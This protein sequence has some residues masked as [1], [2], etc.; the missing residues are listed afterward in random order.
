[1]TIR[2]TFILASLIAAPL[3]V[4]MTACMEEGD[5]HDDDDPM[6]DGKAD[7]SG[8]PLVGNLVLDEGPQ[9]QGI[10]FKNEDGSVSRNAYVTFSLSGPAVLYFETKHQ[11]SDNQTVDGLNRRLDT[12]VFVYKPDGDRWGRYLFRDDNSGEGKFS[13]FDVNLGAGTYH[14]LVKR[15]NGGSRRV[16]ATDLFYTCRG[17]GCEA[18]P[19]PPPTCAATD[20]S[21]IIGN[22]VTPLGGANPALTR[23]FATVEALPPAVRAE[24]R[25]ASTEIDGRTVAGTDYSAE[26]V[27]IYGVLRTAEDSTISAYVVHGQGSSAA[28]DFQDGIVIGIDRAGNRVHT[29]EDSQ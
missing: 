28:D 24:A 21:C 1:M 10:E 8:P 27:G 18:A 20:Y 7:G 9:T 4:S 25:R 23:E 2:N 6:V 14:L 15:K 29:E 16:L 19:P 12:V 26:V 17:P 11:E 5:E 3:T 22:A 13:Q